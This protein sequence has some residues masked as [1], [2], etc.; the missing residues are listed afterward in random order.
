MKKVLKVSAIVLASLLL[1]ALVA[2]FI[3]P[4]FLEQPL[5]KALVEEFDKQTKQNYELGFD[6]LDISLF[7]RSISVDSIFVKPDSTSPHV[8]QITATS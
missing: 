8:Q 4:I 6:E 7:S 5:K 3:L 1:I 2:T